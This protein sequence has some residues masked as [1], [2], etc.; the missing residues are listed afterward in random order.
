MMGIRNDS[1]HTISSCPDYGRIRGSGIRS[2]G[3]RGDEIRDDI[4]ILR[5]LV[6]ILGGLVDRIRNGD[7]WNR[8]CH[9]ISSCSA[10]D[11]I[12]GGLVEILGELVSGILGVFVEILGKLTGR[13]LGGLVEIGTSRICT[14]FTL[15]FLPGNTLPFSSKNPIIF[16]LKIRPIIS[17]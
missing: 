10:R 3:I 1:C 6:R 17:N 14:S 15:A 4:E 13:I 7:S 16:F 11:R 9:T 5:E 2:D 8:D 12:F